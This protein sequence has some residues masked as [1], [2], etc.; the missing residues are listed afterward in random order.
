MR[1][2]NEGLQVGKNHIM[3]LPA[4]TH[5]YKNYCIRCPNVVKLYDPGKT[6]EESQHNK[7]HK[8]KE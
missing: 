4:E 8:P 3:D 6:Q 1:K 2:C 7:L 5:I